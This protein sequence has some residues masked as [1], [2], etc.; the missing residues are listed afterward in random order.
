M[1]HPARRT[2]PV[3]LDLTTTNDELPTTNYQLPTTNYQLPTTN[4]QLLLF[5]GNGAV[6]SLIESGFGLVV[7]RGRNLLL[8]ALDFELEELLLQRLQ[9][10][11]GA[12]LSRSSRN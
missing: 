9:Q 2:G 8:L 3:C 5:T 1:P 4:Y 12:I 10:Q 6:Q 7:L 11:A